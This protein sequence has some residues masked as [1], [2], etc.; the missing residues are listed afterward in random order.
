MCNGVVHRERSTHRAADHH[1]RTGETLRAHDRFKIVHC[2]ELTRDR[3]ALS[4]A[5][6]VVAQH[7]VGRRKV[8]NRRMPLPVVR[9]TGVQKHHLRPFASNLVVELCSLVVYVSRR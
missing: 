3:F 8:C 2:P 1:A 9:N 7:A 4:K 5:T 6:L